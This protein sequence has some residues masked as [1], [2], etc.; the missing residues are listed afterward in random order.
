MSIVI[1]LMRAVGKHPVVLADA[2]AFA[3]GLDVVGAFSSTPEFRD[4]ATRAGHRDGPT[5]ARGVHSDFCQ[6]IVEKWADIEGLA[7]QHSYWTGRIK[8]SEEKARRRSALAT[9]LCLNK[10]QASKLCHASEWMGIKMRL[11]S[12]LLMLGH[13][14]CFFLNKGTIENYYIRRSEAGE[15]DKPKAA[16]EEILHFEQSTKEEIRTAYKDIVDAMVYAAQTEDIDEGPA[17]RDLTLAI[18]GPALAN[19]EKSTDADLNG[20][21]RELIGAKAD[22]FDLSVDREK[23]S[24]LKIELLSNILNVSGF[25][26][27]LRSKENLV[28]SVARQ[29]NLTGEADG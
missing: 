17:I 10:E 22:L 9:L 21:A 14:G 15:A 23:K 18:A 27:T 25:P 24:S 16:I 5:F 26:L 28:E 20:I 7:I 13:V 29:M 1:K 4:V 2:D 6:M 8:G 11:E 19:C 3:D 12:L